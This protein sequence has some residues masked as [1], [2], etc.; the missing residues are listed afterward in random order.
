MD[1][2]SYICIPTYNSA[3]LKSHCTFVTARDIYYRTPEYT[4]THTQLATIN[5]TLRARV[6][7]FCIRRQSILSRLEKASGLAGVITKIL[8]EG[9][10][11]EEKERSESVS[12]PRRNE[13]RVIKHSR[14]SQEDELMVHPV[15]TSHRRYAHAAGHNVKRVEMSEDTLGRR[16]VIN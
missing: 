6:H 1:L 8:T 12:L 16:F 10:R 3:Q 7:I 14:D 15:G 2:R 13:S 11:G 4:H 5:Y 9:S